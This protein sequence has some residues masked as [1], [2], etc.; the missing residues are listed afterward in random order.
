MPN[1]EYQ[2]KIDNNDVEIL[3]IIQPQIVTF[4]SIWGQYMLFLDLEKPG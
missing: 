2:K 3:V 1:F 4:L